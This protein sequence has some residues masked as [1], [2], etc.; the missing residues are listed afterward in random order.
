MTV[1][2]LIHELSKQD[3]D[4]AVV[5]SGAYASEGDIFDVEEHTDKWTKVKRVIIG[6]DIMSG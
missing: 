1:R 2:E 3:Q 5:V 6:S 4:L